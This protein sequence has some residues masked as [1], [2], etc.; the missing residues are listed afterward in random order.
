MKAWRDGQIL[1]Q[2]LILLALAVTPAQ[3]F[4]PYYCLMFNPGPCYLDVYTGYHF[5]IQLS[6][7]HI[8]SYNNVGTTVQNKA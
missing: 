4:L 1:Q 5:Y 8:F 2:E 3:N 7:S 6:I